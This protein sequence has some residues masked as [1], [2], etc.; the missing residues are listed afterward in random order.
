MKNVEKAL[1]K[2]FSLHDV[3][4]MMDVITRYKR[5][6]PEYFSKHG[7][8]GF[9]DFINKKEKHIVPIGECDI[10]EFNKLLDNR[11]HPFTWTFGNCDLEFVNQW[12]LCSDCIEEHPVKG[13]DLCKYCTEDNKML[14]E[15]E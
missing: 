6:E 4:M 11:R 2:H 3:G 14:K 15:D 8:G 7:E 12:K 1:E 13:S 5:I 9:D 10:E